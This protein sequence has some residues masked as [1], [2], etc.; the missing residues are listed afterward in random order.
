MEKTWQTEQSGIVSFWGLS[1]WIIYFLTPFVIVAVTLYFLIPLL[2]P[3]NCSDLNILWSEPFLPPAGREGKWH[4]VLWEYWSGSW[5]IL[6]LD[7]DMWFNNF[8]NHNS[9][10]NAG[11]LL[12]NST[13]QL[14]WMA[15]KWEPVSQHTFLEFLMCSM[16]NLEIVSTCYT[17]LSCFFFFISSYNYILIRL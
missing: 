3:V 14:L 5:R 7:Y 2:F 4:M 8:V 1:L 10:V 6:F 17:C 13:G 12:S 11:W 15:S 9:S 16:F